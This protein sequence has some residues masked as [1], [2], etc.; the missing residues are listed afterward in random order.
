MEYFLLG[1]VQGWQTSIK[2]GSIKDVEKGRE[3]I[4]Q[5]ARGK[6]DQ[7]TLTLGDVIHNETAHCTINETLKNI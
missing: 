5:Y 6:C 3:E 1:G 7:S 4:W 2:Q